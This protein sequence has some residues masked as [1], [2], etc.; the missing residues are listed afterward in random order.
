MQWMRRENLM[1]VIEWNINHRYGH[2]KK[3][4]PKWIKDV[5]DE[6]KA[7]IIVLT[8]TSFKIPNWEDEY[9]NL[10]DRNKYYVFCS[11]NT[12][13]GNNEV[14]ITI[15]KDCFN[16]EYI[17]S[18][19]SE[20]HL[21]PDHLEVHCI[22]KITKKKF[23]VVGVRIH[24]MNISNQQKR[25]EFN[26]VLESVKYDENVMIVGDFNNYRRGFDDS[27]WCLSKIDELATK[28]GFSM[29]TPQGGSIYKDNDGAYSFPEDHIFIKGQ[30]NI[31]TCKYERSLFTNRDTTVYKWK[32]DFQKYRGKDKN[33]EYLYDN[34]DDSFPD[35]AIIEAGI[36]L[37]PAY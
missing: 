20:G 1:K 37:P 27:Y 28:E 14:T 9:R 25:E 19:L 16:I 29:Y 12:A 30:L 11:N 21:Y 6:E 13:V 24:A 18:Y 31:N 5:I 22:H 3:K 15:E 36:H 4:M 35:H 23:V 2:S 34:I 7:T 32:T 10:F 8:E 33:G 17:K 26:T